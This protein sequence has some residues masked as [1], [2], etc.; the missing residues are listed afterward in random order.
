MPEVCLDVAE[1]ESVRV[2][3]NG[4]PFLSMQCVAMLT[5]PSSKAVWMPDEYFPVTISRCHE[6]RLGKDTSQACMESI[7]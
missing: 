4:L 6:S 3:E 2:G 5:P 7:K 1:K